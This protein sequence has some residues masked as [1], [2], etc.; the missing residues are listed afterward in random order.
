MSGKHWTWLSVMSLFAAAASV[1]ISPFC[2]SGCGPSMVVDPVTGAT[3]PATQEDI[4][5]QMQ[6]GE[7]ALQPALAAAGHPEW[8]LFLDAGTR[9]GALLVALYGGWKI[10]APVGSQPQPSGV[11]GVSTVP[12]PVSSVPQAGVAGSGASGAAGPGVAQLPGPAA[13]PA[14]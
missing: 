4:Y 8:Y 12:Q 10:P 3:R 1:G 14:G 5:A 7:Q 11:G 2:G 6:P 9:I 13:A